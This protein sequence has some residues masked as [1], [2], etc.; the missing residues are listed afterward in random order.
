VNGLLWDATCIVD[1]SP[2]F[3]EL[4]TGDFSL[5][6]GSPAIDA[7]DPASDYS[8]EPEPNGCRANMG[9]YGNTVD[10]ASAEGAQHC[11]Q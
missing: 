2:L 7:G 6:S 1:E 8:F 11:P 5:Q 3:V 9:A 4:I 10:A